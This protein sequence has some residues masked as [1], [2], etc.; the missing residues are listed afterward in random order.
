MNKAKIDKLLREV[1]TGDEQSFEQLYQGTKNGVYAFLHTYLHNRADTEDALQ[2]VFLKVKLYISSY[3]AGTNGNAWLLQIAK[4]T[5][6]NIIAKRKQELPLEEAVIVHNDK[7]NDGSITGV[8]QR[9][10]D[11]EEQRVVTLHVLWS[12]KHREIAQMMGCPT[13][14]I[15]SKYK[16]AIAKLQKSLKETTL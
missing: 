11:E 7:Y 12:Y 15:T 5:A 14:T 2:T 1:A 9:V 10:L 6:L 4:N 3:K 8:M 16:R 13:S